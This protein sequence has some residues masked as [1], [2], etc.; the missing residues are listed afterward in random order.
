[1][2]HILGPDGKWYPQEEWEAAQKVLEGPSNPLQPPAASTIR[3]ANKLTN[4]TLIERLG[5]EDRDG[6]SFDLKSHLQASVARGSELARKQL[7][8]LDN[9]DHGEALLFDQEIKLTLQLW[10]DQFRELYSEFEIDSEDSD[11]DD[12]IL[13]DEFEEL[14]DELFESWA[15]FFDLEVGISIYPETFVYVFE[16][17]RKSKIEIGPFGSQGSG[18]GG[19]D[20]YRISHYAENLV[21]SPLIPR[22]LLWDISIGEFANDMTFFMAWGG[23]LDTLPAYLVGI[24]ASPVTSLNLLKAIHEIEPDSAQ[25]PAFCSYIKSWVQFPLLVNPVSDIWLLAK[26]EPANIANSFFNSFLEKQDM[27]TTVEDKWDLEGGVLGVGYNWDFVSESSFQ[28]LKLSQELAFDEDL[29]ATA[30]L[31]QRIIEEFKCERARIEDHVNSES[32]IVRAVVFCSPESSSSM[33]QGINQEGSVFEN[34]KFLD[35]IRSFWV[36]NDLSVVI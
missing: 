14:T 21:L 35:L 36:R 8:L 4:Q 27:T 17:L 23:H 28:I 22:T 32:G 12:F 13:S 10:E 3:L 24:C 16:G 2:S 34:Q 30:L 20:N 7:L 11:L 19:G 5:I 9:F 15:E 26:L 25:V 18:E 1:M 29:F 31:A 33:K 6:M